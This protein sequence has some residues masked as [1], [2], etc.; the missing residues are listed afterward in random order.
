MDP[1]M[2]IAHDHDLSVIEDCAQAPGALY[3]GKKTGTIG[4]LGAFKLPEDKEHDDGRGWDG[5]HGR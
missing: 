4:N 2:E 5:Y 1:I 3:K